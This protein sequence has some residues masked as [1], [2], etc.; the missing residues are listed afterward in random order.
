MSSIRIEPFKFVP[1]HHAAAALLAGIALIGCGSVRTPAI[2]NDSARIYARPAANVEPLLRQ[3][4]ARW[5]GTPH[6]LGGASADGM[7]CSAF[8]QRVFA[9]ALS[10]DLP[11]VTED[12]VKVGRRVNMSEL[13]PGDL[14]FFQPPTKTN[15]VGIYLN[16]GEFAHVSSTSGVTISPLDLEYWRT[17]Y[18]T[19]RRV[20]SDAPALAVTE[21]V[22]R[23]EREEIEA[24]P[25]A[26]PPT[27]VQ[28]V[29]W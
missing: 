20:L 25:P 22:R 4:V 8:V 17:S 5:S 14:V 28:R 21:E 7:D 6:V 27:R 15:H 2:G 23:D 18:W 13:A 24:S 1:F 26:P 3:E 10:I 29:G 9:D 16:E 11:R 19:S 12:Q